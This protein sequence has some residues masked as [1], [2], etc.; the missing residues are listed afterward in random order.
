MTT[1]VTDKNKAELKRQCMAIELANSEEVRNTTNMNETPSTSVVALPSSSAVNLVIPQQ[2]KQVFSSEQQ[3]IMQSMMGMLQDIVQNSHLTIF[4][5]NGCYF[6]KVCYFKYSLSKQNRTSN[7]N[8]T[9][10]IGS[11]SS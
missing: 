3:A 6:K 9:K 5:Y 7:R 1:Y 11:I 8:I 10:N 2:P 4:T